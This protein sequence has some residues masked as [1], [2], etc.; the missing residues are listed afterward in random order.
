MG[1]PSTRG[2]SLPAWAGML[3]LASSIGIGRF[4]YTPILPSMAAAL[5]LSRSQAGLIASA[6]FA[7]YLAG[8]LAAAWR[9]PVSRAW[10]AASLATGCATTA[11]MALL[12]TMA[13]FLA[14][15]FAGGAASAF[16]MV[17]G[18]AAA[19]DTLAAAG[20]PGLA[21]IHYSGV[22]LGIA[23]SAAAI[24]VL[25]ASGAGWRQLWLA[26]GL[27]SAAAATLP[28]V[29]LAGKAARGVRSV[30]AVPARDATLP[31]GLASLSA[32]HALFGFGYVVTATFLVAMVR[33]SPAARSLEPVAWL[34]VG[35]AAAPSTLAWNW[36]AARNGVRA[37]YAAACCLEAAGVLLGGLWPSPTG[38][39]AAAWL[40]GATFMGLTALGFAAARELGQASQARSFAALT[41]AFGAGQVVG[42]AVG[43]ALADVSGSYAAGSAIAASALLAAAGIV[44]AGRQPAR[45]QGSADKGETP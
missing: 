18:T 24:T 14:L 38:L 2:A 22:G 39:L 7:G 31:R 45:R 43:G 1:Q 29:V 11:A 32:C 26:A 34:A 13:G 9:P 6:N 25:D 4:S 5:H 21:W 44:L 20:R 12:S 40:L 27:L 33:L 8:A 10:L 28:A 36:V 23:A 17:L 3:A 35:L 37:A 15:R 19:L 30:G 41:A 16:V 42:P